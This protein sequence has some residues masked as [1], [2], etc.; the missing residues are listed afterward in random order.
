MLYSDSV[1]TAE[2]QFPLIAKWNSLGFGS[3]EHY[4]VAR[5]LGQGGLGGCIKPVGIQRPFFNT[6][7]QAGLITDDGCASKNLKSE[8]ELKKSMAVLP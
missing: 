8:I 1:E 5:A 2:E 4:A 3:N 7:L 6:L